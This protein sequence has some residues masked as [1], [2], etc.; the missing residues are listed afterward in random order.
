MGQ[1]EGILELT[2]WR[3]AELEQA[4]PNLVTRDYQITSP[5]DTAYNCVAWAV[6]D[7][8][9]FWYSAR[10]KGYYWP[11]GVD[12]ADT[13]EG[14]KQVFALHGYSDVESDAFDVKFEKIAI[15][16]DAAGDPS[17]VARQTET[18]EWTSKLGKGYDIQHSTLDV[19]EGDEYGKVAVI[20]QRLCKDGKRVQPLLFN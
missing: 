17:H 16:V 2:V 13:L 7:M 11:P 4:F 9:H 3:D 12:S 8:T 5:K 1:R 18:G 14:W 10:V 20:M 15:Y 19:L 6:G